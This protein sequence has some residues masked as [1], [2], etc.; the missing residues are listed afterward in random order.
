MLAPAAQVLAADTDAARAAALD[1]AAASALTAADAAND[2]TAGANDAA[3][4]A[5]DAVDAAAAAT[6]AIPTTLAPY[7]AEAQAQVVEATGHAGLAAAS[8]AAAEQDR[9][10][11]EAI[12]GDI[13]AGSV[14]GAMVAPTTSE[15]VD[16][17]PGDPSPLVP[18]REG[19]VTRGVDILVMGG[20]VVHAAR[21]G[22]GRSGYDAKTA[23]VSAI[24]ETRAASGGRGLVL[25]EGEFSLAMGA[26][27][28]DVSGLAAIEA[29]DCALRFSSASPGGAVQT[30][31]TYERVA[32][33]IAAEQGQD[34][35]VVPWPLPIVPGQLLY[36]VSAEPV[37]QAGITAATRGERV[38]VAS[39]ERIGATSTAALRFVAPLRY[40]Y[41]T[42]TYTY[43]SALFTPPGMTAGFDGMALLAPADRTLALS[44]GLRL[45]GA[46][47]AKS[48]I[49]AV[50]ARLDIGGVALSGFY[51]QGLY[52]AL[53]SGT[54]TGLSVSVPLGD[55]SGDTYGILVGDLSDIALVG[56]RVQGGQHALTV[57]GGGV[58]RRSAAAGGSIFGPGITPEMNDAATVSLPC[59][60]RVVGGDYRCRNDAKGLAAIDAHNAELLDVRGAYVW[61]G[62]SLNARR[63]V[64][65]GCTVLFQKQAGVTAQ[66]ANGTYAPAGEEQSWYGIEITDTE[67]T[68]L[69]VREDVTDGGGG[70]VS[71]HTVPSSAFNFKGG[72]Y[73]RL[74][75]KNVRVRAQYNQRGTGLEYRTWYYADPLAAF[76]EMD[77]DV[78]VDLVG[79]PSLATVRAHSDRAT[80]RV[81]GTGAPLRVQAVTGDG[82]GGVTVR[83]SGRLDVDVQMD[84]RAMPASHRQPGVEVIGAEVVEARLDVEGATLYGAY[85]ESVDATVRGRIVRSG[86]GWTSGD[87]DTSRAGL[88]VKCTRAR[89]R[90]LRVPGPAA[91]SGETPT[92]ALGFYAAAPTS[93]AGTISLLDVDVRGVARPDGSAVNS[94]GYGLAVGVTVTE[95]RSMRLQTGNAAAEYHRQPTGASIVAGI[96]GTATGGLGTVAAGAEVWIGVLVAGAATTWAA[97]AQVIALG[98]FDHA[99]WSIR[100]A[101]Q[102]AG[103]YRVYF[104]NISG[105][106]L[107]PGSVDVRVIAFPN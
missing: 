68:G 14:P 50:C 31:G 32:W 40:T 41:R 91:G 33:G 59:T 104:K 85:V 60:V 94:D 90:D 15:V 76:A 20:G 100:V 53:C 25:P 54:V 101:W 38:V 74:V 66:P 17:A 98:A 102:S 8:A 18:V 87:S 7:I 89:L 103:T 62:F 9:A 39:Y 35:V 29:R 70:T 4:R 86:R 58:V 48:G 73:A 47:A 2:A 16:P 77:V 11:V 36:A 34:T 57:G 67:F 24:A 26:G 71:H 69:P 13:I 46:D 27:F 23:L 3:E 55:A 56:C 83:S 49:T 10:A 43:P 61:G 21:H 95:V 97:V 82:V 22:L 105:G 99:Q 30:R 79:T 107:S 51:A 92:Q 72:S 19:S 80:V 6:A 12:A 88:F 52:A 42:G 65:Q 1:G 106:S 84:L 75:L 63:N 5:N 45:E 93:G 28:L 78:R 96:V 81:R 44:D 37:P 64:V